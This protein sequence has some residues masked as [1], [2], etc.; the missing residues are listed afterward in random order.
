M[1]T[2]TKLVAA[3]KVFRTIYNQATAQMTSANAFAALVMIATVI[4]SVGTEEDYRWLGALPTFAEWLG[5]VSTGDLE[6]YSYTLKNKH[7]VGGVAIDRDELEDDRMNIILPRIT[8][9]AERAAVHK[10]RLLHSLLVGGTSNLAYDGVA[11][12]SDVSGKRTIDNL[13]AGTISAGTPTMAQVEADI[14]TVRQAMMAFTD[15]K[16]EIIGIVPDTF[17]IHPKLER[18]FR[19]LQTSTA[20]PAGS[21]SAANNVYRSWIKEV[22]VDPALTDVND[23]YALCTSYAVKPFIWQDRQ[24]VDLNLDSTQLLVNRKANFIADYRGNAG[25]SLPHLAVK[26]VSG[27]A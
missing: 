7:F 26:V 6:E 1:I 4:D 17:I 10:G 25:Y 13:L 2:Q 15:D 22:I 27:V 12:F 24:A 19:Q 14:D 21:N 11:F 9:L 5:D 3:E 18:L 20:D 16:G 8:A 23:F